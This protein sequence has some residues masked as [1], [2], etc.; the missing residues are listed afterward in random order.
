[1]SKIMVAGFVLLETIVKVEGLPV[2]YQPFSSEVNT[3]TSNLGGDGYNEATALTWLGNEVEFMSIWARGMMPQLE[4]LG[5]KGVNL[6]LDYI[7]PKLEEIP[8]SVVLYA[9]GKRQIFEDVKDSRDIQYDYQLFEERIQ[10]K[11]IVLVTDANFCRPLLQ[12]VKKYQKPL[13]LNVRRLNKETKVK[14]EEFLQAADIIY[15][16]GTDVE[17]DPYDWIKEVKE[18][19]NPEVFIIGIGSKGVII[20]TK[21]DNSILEYKPVKTKEIVNTIGAGNALFSAFVHYYFKTKDAKESIKAAL[22]FASYKI[23]FD[24]T[25]NG[26]MTEEQIQQWLPLIWKD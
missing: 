3:I 11:D 24:G 2:R 20:Y 25:T 12:L 18:R 21:A 7:L 15:V 14:K 1:M 5:A 23:G 22:L 17:G 6:K 26:F 10:D 13:A 9:D 19:Y 8:A 4:E 16:S